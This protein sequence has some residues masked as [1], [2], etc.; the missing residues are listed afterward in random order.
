MVITS[1]G[2]GGFLEDQGRWLKEN[3]IWIRSWM[4]WDFDNS[5][6]KQGL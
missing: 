6:Q 4:G 2:K 1:S 3:D 5:L